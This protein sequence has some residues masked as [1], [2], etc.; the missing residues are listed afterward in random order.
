MNKVFLIL[1]FFLSSCGYQA[2][3]QSKNFEKLYFTKI[4]LQ[5][6][7]F[8]NNKIINTLP[9]KESGQNENELNISSSYRIEQSSKNSKGQVELFKTIISVNLEIKDTN[10][11][12]VQSK[13]FI[14]EFTYKNKENKFEL[15]EYQNS[16]KNDLI[17]KIISEIMIYLNS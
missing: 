1:I 15:V 11:Q 17:D 8:I 4:N 10:N 9:I 2:V 13:N 14:K 5:G 3:Y 12:I 6:E 16:I 7:K